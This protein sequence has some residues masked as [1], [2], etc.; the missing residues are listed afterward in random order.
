MA[1]NNALTPPARIGLVG[2]GLMGVPM[3]RNLLAAGYSLTVYDVNTQV[4]SDF[5]AAN[6]AASAAAS[7]RALAGVCDAVITMLPNGKI[8][9]DVVLEGADNLASGLAA[10]TLVIDM[11]SSSPVGTRELGELLAARGLALIDAPVSGGVRRAV[12]ATLAIMIGGDDAQIAR[13]EP[14]L[15][16][17]G[18]DLFRTG[19]LGTAHAMKA[20]NNYVSAA[21]FA[22][23]AEAVLAGT[24]FGLDPA[25]V[26][27][28]L[29]ASTGKNNSTELKFPQQVL[30][31]KFA[32]GFS[33]GLMVKDLRTALE[34]AQATGMKAP[35]AQATV[36]EWA[37]AEALL[38]PGADHTAMVKFVEH[39]AG[40]TIEDG[41]IQGD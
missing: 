13:C 29:N 26:V 36:D 37:G 5:A 3:A 21:G 39:L 4:L 11:S 6:P 31:R 10:G 14:L 1:A 28:V 2:L 41:P 32:A 30:T 12:D 40:S 8:V 24:R 38:G 34:V 25:T 9:R 19:G 20:L 22:A 23:A 17:M 18:R 7:L 35:I 16:A 27:S 33:L 15:K